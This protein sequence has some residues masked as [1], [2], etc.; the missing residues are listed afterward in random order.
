MTALTVSDLTD[1]V[2]AIAN[3]APAALDFSEQ[4]N[5]K[6]FGSNCNGNPFQFPRDPTPA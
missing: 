2:A 3:P 5:W 4:S 1:S 6:I